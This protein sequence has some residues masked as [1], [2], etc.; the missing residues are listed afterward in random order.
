ML[1]YLLDISS[2]PTGN[3]TNTT[4]P[5]SKSARPNPAW[6]VPNFRTPDGAKRWR[7]AYRFAGKQKTLAIGVYP[8]TGLRDA[9]TAC[10]EAKRLLAS[11]ID[12]G[13][14]KKAVALR[15]LG[16]GKDEMIPATASARRPRPCSMKAGQLAHVENNS[17]RRA[18]HRAI[19]GTSASA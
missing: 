5:T 13:Q 10:E 6:G 3:N 7:L 4:S 15:R 14:Q 9:R 11:R 16:C 12:P 18:Y 2:R 17:V 1:V 8:G 19:I